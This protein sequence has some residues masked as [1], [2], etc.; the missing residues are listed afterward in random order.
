MSAKERAEVHPENVENVTWLWFDYAKVP[1][2]VSKFLKGQAERIHRSAGKSIIEIG[3]DLIAAKHYLSHGAF[4]GWV[5]CEVG[6]PARTAQAYMQVAHWASGRNSNVAHLSPTLL[7]LL[8]A[9]STPNEFI[10]DV[11]KRIEAGDRITLSDIREELKASR[12]KRREW[13]QNRGSVTGPTAKSDP[14]TNAVAVQV[15]ADV[16]VMEAVAILARTLPASEFDRVRNIMTDKAVLADPSLAQKIEMAFQNL[17]ADGPVQGEPTSS[18]MP[19]ALAD[20]R[21]IPT[22]PDHDAGNSR[23]VMLGN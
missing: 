17:G 23:C 15:E 2:S 8:S 5:V 21:S 12:E 16:K 18:S 14:L 13:K 9:P 6:I 10:V 19:T 4:L 11:L 20:W 22:A 1:A 7:Y 3:K